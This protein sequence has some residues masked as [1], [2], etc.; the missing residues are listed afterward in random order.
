MQEAEKA[1]QKLH[2]DRADTSLESYVRAVHGFEPARHHM[3]WIRLLEDERVKRLLVIA[4]PEHAKSTYFSVAFPL[5]YLGRN[6]EHSVLLI[7]NT[8]SQAESFFGAIQRTIETNAAYKQAFPNVIP[9]RDAG[10]TRSA[11]YL[12][13]EDRDRP[14]PS[15]MA[16]GVMGPVL[17]RRAEVIIVDDP[18]DQEM[19]SSYT[20][21]AQLKAWFKQTLMTRLK[22]DGR[23][24]CVMTRWHQDDLAAELMRTEMGFATLVMPALGYWKV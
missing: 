4:P 6:P 13:R 15:L 7:S 16:C 2:S 24:L 5:W 20:Q 1:K 14:D 9:D 19:A 23:M 8:A 10:W 17:G 22:A 18:M 3:K 21:R 12:K 11:L